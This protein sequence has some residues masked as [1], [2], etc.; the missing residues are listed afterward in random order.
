MSSKYWRVG[1][2][3][4]DVPEIIKEAIKIAEQLLETNQIGQLLLFYNID[5]TSIRDVSIEF[6]TA[7]IEV[8]QM[9]L[10]TDA[11]GKFDAFE[12]EDV[13]NL[14]AELV[15]LCKDLKP[16]MEGYNRYKIK[17]RFLNE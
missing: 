3:G 1:N 15:A 16:G 14:S 10:G 11:C 13:I 2:M 6:A 5:G 7:N 17:T 12:N 8:D 9:N 4:D